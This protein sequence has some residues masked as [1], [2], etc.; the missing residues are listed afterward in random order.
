MLIKFTLRLE[1][2]FLSS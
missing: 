2:C 1:I